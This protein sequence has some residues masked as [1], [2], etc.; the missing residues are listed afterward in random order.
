MSFAADAAEVTKGRLTGEITGFYNKREKGF[1]SSDYDVDAD[2]SEWGIAGDIE[3]SPKDR[4]LLAFERYR[5][6][7]GERD[8][9]ARLI[10]RREIDKAWSIEAGVSQTNRTSPLST[11]SNNGERVDAGLRVIWTRDEDTSAWAFAQGTVSHSGEMA[12]N[13][14][15]GLGAKLRLTET[16]SAEAEV[17]AG[18]LG[19]AGRMVLSQDNGRGTTYHMGYS[20]DPMRASDRDVMS[21]GGVFVA[22][23]SKKINDQVQITTEAS[24]D[25][26]GDA[27]A[28]TSTYG[29]SYA[30]DKVWTH[31]A[32]FDYGQTET[33]TLG[34]FTRKGL[35]LG[36][37]YLQDE[38]FEASLR[39]EY[40][41]DR[42][43]DGTQNRDSWM[44]E[45]GV[46]Y[47]LNEEHRLLANLAMVV[48]DSD[49]SSLRDGR[50]I[51]ANL[52]YAYRPIKNDQLNLLTRYTY[53]E[54]LPGPDQVNIAGDIGGPRQKSH[55][56]SFDANYDIDTQWTLGGK[57]GHR[58]G[59]VE[60]RG[61]GVF[62]DNTA[63]LGVARVT[64]HFTHRWDGLIEG[65]MLRMHESNV[66]QKGAV[67]SIH[68]HVGRNA[69]IGVGYQ[70]GK[71]SDDMRRIEGKS[72]GPFINVLMKF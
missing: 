21:D 17:S 56:F 43:E 30:P 28:L 1:V 41:R 61:S 15:F 12:T 19:G 16:L 39:G 40:R 68:R 24:Y 44:V 3:L 7:E 69:K 47:R 33:A 62:V 6:E 58:R 8:D 72:A 34:S 42:S 11:S 54:D 64:Y 53:I 14:R 55:I 31:T 49:Q 50:Y 23:A 4:L 66:T 27:P 35:S 32:G 63:T 22:G 48:S 65:R 52:G 60:A 37:R 70:W 26:L 10:Y 5:D 36:T 2:E 25:R 18:D 51:E 67:A 46:N 59:Q 38:W 9:T 13:D 71:V 29:V 20:L 57:I 45:G